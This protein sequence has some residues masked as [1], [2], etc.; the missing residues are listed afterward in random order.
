MEIRSPRARHLRI[1]PTHGLSA[2]FS[3]LRELWEFRDLLLLLA[4]RDVKLRY[5]QTALGITWVVLQP[6]AS[7]FV[8]AIIFGRV[9]RLPS[10]G[11]PYLLFVFAG[12]LPWSFFASALQRA[13]TSL[14]ADSRLITKVY[15]P[16]MIIPIASVAA[17]LLDFL[18]SL[19]VM[20]ALL[21]YYRVAPT[22][23]LTAIPVLLA[24]TFVAAVGVSLA[25]SA[26]NVYYRDFVHVLPFLVQIWMYASPLVYSARMVPDE[27]RGV[28]MLNPLV[29]IIGGFRWSLL[30]HT[31]FPWLAVS[32]AAAMSAA[33]L[34]AGM[35]IFHR[36][37][38]SFADVI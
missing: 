14:I 25:L 27:W 9:A 12:I 35:L 38:R 23:N 8:F 20:M 22:A 30:A 5:R 7:C 29:G 33:L 1:Q 17:V 13:G 10:E 28:Y 32:V 15:F 37:G 11:V 36:V 18:V 4:L 3:N 24:V 34:F 31:N 26:L 21:A 6:L 19:I 16:R 2:V